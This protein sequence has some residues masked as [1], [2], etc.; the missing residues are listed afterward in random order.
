MWNL[1]RT[2]DASFYSTPWFS[3]LSAWIVSHASIR[4]WTFSY[5]DFASVDQQFT[6]SRSARVT[7]INAG[8]KQPAGTAVADARIET[9][10]PW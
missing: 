6:A 2:D 7:T 5:D 4:D 1:V 8:K 3:D 9:S 10:P